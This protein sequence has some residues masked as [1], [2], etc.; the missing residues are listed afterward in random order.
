LRVI[1]FN[2][3]D[4]AK[5]ELLEDKE[6]LNDLMKEINNAG[7]NDQEMDDLQKKLKKDKEDKEDKD[8]Q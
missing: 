6:F 7:L 4:Q 8:K 1:Y 3:L 5:D 2:P